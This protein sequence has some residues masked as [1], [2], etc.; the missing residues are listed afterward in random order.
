VGVSRTAVS[1]RLKRLVESGVVRVVGIVH[2]AVAGLTTVAHVSIDVRGPARGVL[3]AIVS[4]DAASFVSLIAGRHSIVTELRARDDS[5]LELELDWMRSLAGVI[6]LSVFRRAGL[7]KDVY[8]V[9]RAFQ[10]IPLDHVDVQLLKE[11]QRDG[12]ASYARL[13]AGVGLSQNAT[14]ARV[15]RLIDSG[16]VRVTGLVDSSAFGMREHAG[17]GLRV[18]G[19]ARAVAEQVAD[20]AGIVYVLTGYGRFDVLV[21]ADAASRIELADTI[22]DVRAVPGVAELEAWHHLTVLKESYAVDLA[23]L[24]AV[25]RE[26]AA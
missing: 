24:T 5:A 3:D 21:A 18:E 26:A 1:A 12:R 10:H 16:T 14:R 7:V 20:V 2:A 9:Q 22:E 25:S 6:R 13:A 17:L 4:R 15:V 23:S 8:S 11:L 19:P